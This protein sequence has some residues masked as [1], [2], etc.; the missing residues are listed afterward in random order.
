MK[1]PITLLLFC[2]LTV[3]AFAQSNNG[4][5]YHT[6][7]N[8]STRLSADRKST[9]EKRFNSKY[10]NGM[11][12][13]DFKKSAAFVQRSGVS[14]VPGKKIG[15]DLLSAAV[16]IGV[17]MLPGKQWKKNAVNTLVVK[18]LGKTASKQIEYYLDPV[19]AEEERKNQNREKIIEL[20]VQ[21]FSGGG[22]ANIAAVRA[23][24]EASGEIKEEFGQQIFSVAEE[25]YR[26]LVSSNA[27]L[28]TQLSLEQFRAESDARYK[29]HKTEQKRFTEGIAT[30]IDLELR[31]AKAAEMINSNISSNNEQIADLQARIIDLRKNNK[32]AEKEIGQLKELT[33]INSMN[34][35]ALRVATQSNHEA[36]IRIGN[37]VIKIKNDVTEMKA[38]IK[39]ISMKL[40]FQEMSLEQRIETLKTNKY[41][42]NFKSRGAKDSLIRSYETVLLKQKVAGIV[43]NTYAYGQVAQQAMQQFKIGSPSFQENF[44]YAVEAAGVIGAAYAGNYPAALSG[45]LN[46]IGKK[47][48]TSP[49]Q[50]MLRQIQQQLEHLEAVMNMQF[51]AVHEHLNFLDTTIRM[52]FEHVDMT[53]Q[54]IENKLDYMQEENNKNFCFI[55]N[56]LDAIDN[57]IKCT[58]KLINDNQAVYNN[59]DNAYEGTPDIGE[60]D[61]EGLRNYFNVYGSC[62]ANLHGQIQQN[63][64]TNPIFNHV[65]CENSQTGAMYGRMLALWA[66]SNRRQGKLTGTDSLY[67]LSVA[68]LNIAESDSF[69]KRCLANSREFISSNPFFEKNSFINPQSAR[70]KNAEGI[71]KLSKYILHFLPILEIYKGGENRILDSLSQMRPEQITAIENPLKKLVQLIDLSIAQNLLLDGNYLVSDVEEII[72]GETRD[73]HLVTLF[74][75][76]ETNPYF[77]RNLGMYL[78]T[79]YYRDP[80]KMQ[81]EITWGKNNRNRFKQVNGWLTLYSNSEGQLFFNI[82]TLRP[83]KYRIDSDTRITLNYMLAVPGDELLFGMTGFQTSESTL[84][85]LQR[86]FELEEVLSGYRHFRQIPKENPAQLDQLDLLYLYSAGEQ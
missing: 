69:Y 66:A 47:D 2:F 52:R 35:Q 67:F 53:L 24:L 49:E 77:E 11:S 16:E 22:P 73:E 86:K 7:Y 23:E 36:S 79:K 75:L 68:P 50:Q 33:L 83:V 65:D 27:V 34:L 61:I 78:A 59:C 29:E 45:A 4:Y 26:A 28:N 31:N 43:N 55:I 9:L 37:D 41:D 19:K 84:E 64:L 44:G 56:K 12:A 14:S 70:Y 20:A 18:S 51:D 21:R 32:N 85:L 25:K 3:G 1:H 82:Q 39:S 10:P 6:L 30:I 13:A 15:V 76:L 62:I 57:Q 71:N 38:D 63:I 80:A 72:A 17:D 5:S 42:H 46:M 81:E 58:M 8:S 54:R 40:D 60:R 48:K 74:D